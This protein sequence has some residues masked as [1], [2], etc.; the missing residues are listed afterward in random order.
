[1][2]RATSCS[3]VEENPLLVWRGL[4]CRKLGRP[5][6]LRNLCRVCSSLAR[7]YVLALVSVACGFFFLFPFLGSGS[8]EREFFSQPRR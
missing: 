8:K 1:M 7:G 4:W 6:H 5:D 2:W 3:L